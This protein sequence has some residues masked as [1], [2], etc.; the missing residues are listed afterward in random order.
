MGGQRNS[1]RSFVS[2]KEAELDCYQRVVLMVVITGAGCDVTGGAIPLVSRKPRYVIK[3]TCGQVE[4]QLG[5]RF[6]ASVGGEVSEGFGHISLFLGPHV[7]FRYSITALAQWELGL[8][9]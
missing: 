3:C 4:N 8:A 6:A 5:S 1:E 2:M 9:D 7:Y